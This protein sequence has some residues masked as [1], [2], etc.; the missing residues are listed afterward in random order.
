[1]VFSRVRVTLVAA[2]SVCSGTVTWTNANSREVAFQFAQHRAVLS[3]DRPHVRP[4]V[5]VDV[6]ELEQCHIEL[7]GETVADQGIELGDLAERLA[8][9]PDLVVGDEPAAGPV[10]DGLLLVQVDVFGG[11][12]P[13]L[14]GTVG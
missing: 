4:G 6:A 9:R 10:R 8:V 1:M 14:P 2:A 3:E 12:R 5:D 11:C 7:V 13:H